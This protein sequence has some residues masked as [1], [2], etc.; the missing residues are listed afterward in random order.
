M[1]QVKF[2]RKQY[3]RSF[4]ALSHNNKRTQVPSLSQSEVSSPNQNNRF[5][6]EDENKFLKAQ[7]D[8]L[9]NVIVGMCVVS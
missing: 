6:L 2:D 5:S 3:Q 7:I 8:E 4:S 9:K 1:K